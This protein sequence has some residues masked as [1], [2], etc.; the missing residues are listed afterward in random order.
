[1]R[2]LELSAEGVTVRLTIR[3]AT[4]SDAMRRGMLAAKAAETD[5]PSDVEQA[6]A[7]MVYPRCIAC[8][9]GEIERNGETKSIETLTPS[10]F[11]ELPYEIG[12]RWLEAA[13][14][15]NPGWSLQP[16]EERDS[17]KKD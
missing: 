7:V 4:V 1:M 9:Q 16:L 12:E 3:H 6:V 10:E 17:E 5:Y 11:C 2:N 8:T 13:L 15:E 14:E